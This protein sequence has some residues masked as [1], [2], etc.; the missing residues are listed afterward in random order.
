MKYH[1]IGF[2][3]REIDRHP[4]SFS[5]NLYGMVYKLGGEQKMWTAFSMYQEA[6]ART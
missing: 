6:K 3:S 4:L 1:L 2:W 5:V